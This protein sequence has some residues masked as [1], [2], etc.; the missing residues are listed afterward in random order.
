MQLRDYQ[1]ETKNRIYDNFKT[2]RRIMA[3]L[4]TGAGKTVLFTSI[5]KDFVEHK[6]R[7]HVVW[8]LVHRKE[9]IDQTIQKAKK[10]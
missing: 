4:P 1:Q 10:Y 3:Q 9:L 5:A 7:R 6:K 2:H 8:G